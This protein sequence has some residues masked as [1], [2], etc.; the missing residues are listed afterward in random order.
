MGPDPSSLDDYIKANRGRYTDEAIRK[1]LASAGHDPV[2]IDEAYRRVTAP[3]LATGLVTEAWI[4]LG[5]CGVLGLIGFGMASS[6]GTSSGLPLFLLGYAAI[7][8]GLALLLRWAVPR[9]GIRGGWG[10]LIG[11]LLVPAYGALMFG[12]CL[13][14]FK[15]GQV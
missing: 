15:I 7:G 8:A 14:A 12:T 10:E 9:F 11:F 2:A 5:I 13:A 3:R 4:L 1:T 6:I